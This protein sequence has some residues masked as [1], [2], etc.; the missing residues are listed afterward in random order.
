CEVWHCFA[1]TA[2]TF[3]K[4]VSGTFPSIVDSVQLLALKFGIAILNK[5]EIQDTLE[6]PPNADRQLLPNVF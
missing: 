4:A 6:T 5:S 1:G 3:D 2:C